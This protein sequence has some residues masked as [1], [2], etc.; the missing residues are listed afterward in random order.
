MLAQIYRQRYPFE[1]AS[2]RP[3]AIQSRHY[4]KATMRDGLRSTVR[5][6]RYPGIF[7][8]TFS[9]VPPPRSAVSD[10]QE[11]MADLP[12][13]IPDCGAGCRGGALG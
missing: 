8:R 5:G 10:I 11:A 12:G 1:N 2:P 6:P 9:D 7:S 4:C 13:E 3:G